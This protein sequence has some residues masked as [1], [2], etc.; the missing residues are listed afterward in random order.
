MPPDDRIATCLA[1][2]AHVRTLVGV[3]QQRG[4]RLTV[5]RAETEHGIPFAAMLVQG[6]MESDLLQQVAKLVAERLDGDRQLQI[7][8]AAR[9]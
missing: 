9:N 3:M 4:I 8:G 2:N 7:D 5:V 1:A 6:A